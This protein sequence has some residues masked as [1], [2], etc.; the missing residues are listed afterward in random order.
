MKIKRSIKFIALLINWYLSLN[1]SAFDDQLSFDNDSV[2]S[3]HSPGGSCQ[4][5]NKS[6]EV[7][8]FAI[9]LPVRSNTS[10]QNIFQMDHNI[11]NLQCTLLYLYLAFLQAASFGSQVEASLLNESISASVLWLL[12]CQ[13][14]CMATLPESCSACLLDDDVIGAELVSEKQFLKYFEVQ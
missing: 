5:I 2:H 14:E 4:I 10:A 7:I 12:A 3:E 8:L 6:Y 1:P 9:A 13:G 11:S